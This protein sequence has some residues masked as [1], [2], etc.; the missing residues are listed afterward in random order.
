MINCSRVQF[1]ILIRENFD[2]AKYCFVLILVLDFFLIIELC[3]GD[4]DEYCW[5]ISYF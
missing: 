3:F 4:F 5:Y 2:N 1:R